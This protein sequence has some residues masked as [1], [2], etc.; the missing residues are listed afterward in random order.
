MSYETHFQRVKLIATIFR[1][2]FFSKLV[3]SFLRFKNLLQLIYYLLIFFFS[4]F[5]FIF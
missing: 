2:F 5:E 1:V 4:L 3:V